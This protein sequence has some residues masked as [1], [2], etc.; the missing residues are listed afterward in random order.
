[1]S[2]STAAVRQAVDRN[3]RYTRTKVGKSECER[4]LAG[5]SGSDEDAP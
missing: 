2:C 5:A 1:M 3:L 4:A